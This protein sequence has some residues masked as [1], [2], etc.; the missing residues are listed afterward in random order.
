MKT[1]DSEDEV[2]VSTKGGD[3]V[4]KDRVKNQVVEMEK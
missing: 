4:W 1:E 2:W 3:H